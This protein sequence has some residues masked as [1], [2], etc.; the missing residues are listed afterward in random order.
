M[1]REERSRGKESLLRRERKQSE[2]E[3]NSYIGEGREGD[4]REGDR[5]REKERGKRA[6][7][8]DGGR[9]K[10]EMEIEKNMCRKIKHPAKRRGADHILCHVLKMVRR[11]CSGTKSGVFLSMRSPSTAHLLNIIY[12]RALWESN[13]L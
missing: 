9:K 6:K 12:K 7:E 13:Q 4:E 8:R 2:T 10:S 1:L 11:Q 3:G 5:E